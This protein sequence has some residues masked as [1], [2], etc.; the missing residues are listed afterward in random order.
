MNRYIPKPYSYRVD[1]SFDG[2]TETYYVGAKDVF[3]DG[4]RQVVSANSEF[5]HELINYQN[6]KIP[7]DGR[8]YDIK[9][10]RQ[11]DIENSLL[12][13]YVNLRT[14][15]DII[16]KNG[17]TDPFLVRVLNMRK[18]QHNLTDIF[19]TI[20]ENQN[21][22]V[23]TDFKKNIIVQGC[24]GSGKTMVLLHRLSSLSYRERG[25][26]FS[27]A[28]LILTPNDQFTLHI[29][30]LAEDLQIGNIQRVSVEQYYIDTLLLYSPEFR[31]DGRVSSEMFVRQSFVDYVYSDQF[32]K[33][34]ADA[35]D[36]VIADRNALS[37]I[38]DSLTEALGQPK[39]NIN[40]SDN[41]KVVQQ[42]QYA[43]E[44]MRSLVEK[45]DEETSSARAEHKKLIE[46]KQYLVDRVAGLSQTSAG[47]ARESLP[48]VYAKIGTF[49]SERQHT[50][51][52]LEEQLQ[53]FYD[54]KERLQNS[55]IVFR[56]KPKLEELEKNINTVQ[57]K[58]DK[59]KKQQEEQNAVLLQRMDE[60]N[61][62]DILDWFRQVMLII[63]QVRDEVRLC[64][65]IKEDYRNLSEELS[66][67]DILIESAR[68]K[69]EEKKKVQY[70][71]EIKKTITDLDTELGNYSLTKTFEL[72]FDKAAA[73]FKEAHNIKSISGKY[74]RYSLYARLLFA[75][76]YFRKAVGT[77]HFMC[78][79]EGQDLARNEYRLLYDLNQ[80]NIVFNIFGDTNQLIKTGRG[81][82]DWSE[83][84][85]ALQADQFTLNENYRNTNQITRFC[86]SS[87]DMNVSRTG[88]DRA[89][90]REIPRRDLEK[91][92]AALNVGN[93][94]IAILVP[95]GVKKNQ[96]IDMEILPD[97]INKIIGEKMENGYISLM[98]VDEVK[99]IEFDRV[100]VVPNKMS[101]N[102]KYIAYTRAL[103]E[104]ILVVDDQVADYDDGSSQELSG[105]KTKSPASTKNRKKPAVI[106][107]NT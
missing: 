49:L 67:I 81:I 78:V 13:G 106:N 40:F 80:H 87:F 64:S 61:E 41:T 74:H 98:Y 43:L 86:N 48:R 68:Q 2:K 76:R 65:N 3:L 23:N 22:I 73:S 8:E 100:F 82:S 38:L 20:Q 30:G 52:G 25:F 56:K 21:S 45:R 11:L 88:V 10:T 19:V 14:D 16:F 46:R 92:L 94:R 104:L 70:S 39:R 29:K 50:I 107:Y 95:R 28:A 4:K 47:I 84:R 90:V 53:N 99:G 6:T 59:E 37:G 85:K 103:S 55:I 18:R 105:K 35:Y 91:E 60:A 101:Q 1:I 17:I 79:D 51:D 54:L 42:M 15:E 26:D 12:Y 89:N 34:F 31:L 5:G 77:V 57:R 66:G 83:I 93:E 69:E 63:D 96:Y 32:R 71:D 7:R 62:D 75:M 36:S 33:D 72:I 24:A 58:L 9:L 102:E 97:S 44:S 27:G